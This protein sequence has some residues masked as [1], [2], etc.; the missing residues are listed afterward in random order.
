LR[1]RSA[2][3]QRQ[4]DQDGFDDVLHGCSQSLAGCSPA[5]MSSKD[6]RRRITA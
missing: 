2:K 5:I 3:S 1:G 4:R 6:W